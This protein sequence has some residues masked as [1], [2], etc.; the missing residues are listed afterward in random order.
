MT[1]RPYYNTIW[2]ILFSIASQESLFVGEV[3]TSI[4]MQPVIRASEYALFFSSKLSEEGLK[5]H[6]DATLPT[7]KRL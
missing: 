7:S 6:I 5:I 1:W 2:C 4:Y 3:A